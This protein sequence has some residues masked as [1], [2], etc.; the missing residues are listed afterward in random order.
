[1]F[2]F[3]LASRSPHLQSIL[4]ASQAPSDI[5][6]DD[7]KKVAIVLQ[8]PLRDVQHI[9]ENLVDGGRIADVDTLMD[10]VLAKEH[11]D[12]PKKRKH[13]DKEEDQNKR[14]KIEEEVAAEC[15]RIGL[16]VDGLIC[17]L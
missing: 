9:A 14:R 17:F 1:M 13:E 4:G 10:A 5:S 7:I 2:P 6:G 3:C 11:E 12:E 15:V 16:L 8:K